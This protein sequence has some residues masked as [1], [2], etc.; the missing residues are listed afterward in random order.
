[1]YEVCNLSQWPLEMQ[2]SYFRLIRHV[3]KINKKKKQLL[4]D[5]VHFGD[6]DGK[7]T[8]DLHLTSAYSFPY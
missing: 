7:Q 3:F 6:L 5:Y 1:M 2:I 8:S 4:K